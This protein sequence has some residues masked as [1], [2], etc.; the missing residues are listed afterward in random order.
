MRDYPTSSLLVQ[1]LN[2]FTEAPQLQGELQEISITCSGP[3]SHY[4]SS[5]LSVRWP[6]V[7]HVRKRAPSRQARHV[8]ASRCHSAI[9]VS[10]RPTFL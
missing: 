1:T 5:A 6:L 2:T 3:Y 8:L 10:R 7:G 9:A 4:K